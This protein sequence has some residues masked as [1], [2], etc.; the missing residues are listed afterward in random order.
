MGD[1]AALQTG[2]AIDCA[3]LEVNGVGKTATSLAY[4]PASFRL[5]PNL[6]EGVSLVADKNYRP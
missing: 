5:K 4:P 6:I 2:V 3:S 1:F